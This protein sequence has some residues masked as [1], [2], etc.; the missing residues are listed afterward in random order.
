MDNF[1]FCTPTRYVFG[2][3]TEQ[4]TGTLTR[5]MGA[6][7]VLIV[8]G[9]GS[10]VRSGL[11]DRVKASLDEAGIRHEDLGGI[12]PNP[13]DDR[14]YEGIDIVRRHKLQG[15]VAV[16]GGSA[17]DTAKAIAAG[18][19]YDGDFWDFFSGRRVETALPIGVVL[20]IPAAGSEGSGNSVITRLDGMHKIS[21]RTDWALRPRW[22]VMNPVLT[23]TLPPYQTASGI[24]DMM[25]HVFERYFSNSPVV[26]VTDRISEGILLAIMH[27]APIVM[28]QPDNYDA[29]AEIMWAG[30]LCHNGLCGI[31]RKDD[32]T[33][34]GLEHELSAVY[35]VTH[36]A[37]LAVVFPA[38][39]TF[40]AERHPERGAQLARRIFDVKAKD[41]RTAALEGIAKL[42]QFFKNL[43]L[44]TTLAQL[45]IKDPDYDL[46][47]RKFHEDKGPVV[48]HYL[49]I[50]AADT[51]AIYRLME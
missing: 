9:Q 14:V 24:A 1:T 19:V 49:P 10:V 15:L 40:M 38:W 45:G 32:W 47:V 8:Y 7:S 12:R 48:G 23:F 46:L 29:R 21:I 11:L 37:G 26:E 28:A 4:Q 13:T 22:A 41:D 43:G 25:A 20:T 39:M 44:P 17:I 42:R 31:G 30:T 6:D 18:A 51:L 16:G 34:H 3:D 33:S 27:N 36:G 2:R 5:Q 35:G 50:Q